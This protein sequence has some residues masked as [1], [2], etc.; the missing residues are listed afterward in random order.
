M[1]RA[2]Y[3]LE[4]AHGGVVAGV[5]EAGRGPLAG[6]VVAA[7]V[8]LPARRWPA[9]IA[10]SK[11]L[12]AATREELAARIRRCACVGVGHASVAEID[13]LN[14]F[15]ATMLAM[16]RAIGA[17]E[18]PPDLVLVDGNADPRCGH[19]TRTVVGGDAIC[20]SIAAASI[21]AKVARDAIMA[22]LHAAFPAYGWADNKGYGTPAHQR[23][24]KEHGPSPHHRRGF[25][26][27][28][29]ASESRAQQ[30]NENRPVVPLT[31]ESLAA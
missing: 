26:A 15:W 8:I 24:L 22:E 31:P 18:C 5:D 25:R 6:P 12:D 23:A 3:R 1:P 29:A 4:R 19:P 11:A 16:R 2:T 14:I 21:V 20:L 28:V 9:R 30:L 13:E 27:V 7:A 10:D 17:L